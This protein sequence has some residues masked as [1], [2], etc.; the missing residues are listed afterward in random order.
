MKNLKFLTY[1][2]AALL[3]F[4]TVSCSDDDDDKDLS[5]DKEALLT[6]GVWTG[7]KIFVGGQDF[8]SIYGD[9]STVTMTFD[10]D[11]TYTLNIDGDVKEG[12]WEFTNNNTQVIMDKGPDEVVVDVNRLTSTELWAE[13][14]FID[15]GQRVEVRFVRQ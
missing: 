8:T 9:P 4:T 10:D 7:N 13:G 3:M 6:A 5:P 12:T 15:I 2:F 1:L 14:D 11:G